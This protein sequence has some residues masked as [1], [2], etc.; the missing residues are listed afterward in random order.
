MMKA[1]Y[2]DLGESARSVV[3]AFATGIDA[4]ETSALCA[5]SLVQRVEQ[6]VKL[7]SQVVKSNY[8]DVK[9]WQSLTLYCLHHIKASSKAFGIA[10]TSSRS[11]VEG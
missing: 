7:A 6:G 3:Q 9:L 8:L 5:A 2:A 4:C 1:V 11:T 10:L